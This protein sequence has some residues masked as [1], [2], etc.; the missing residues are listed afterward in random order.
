M[1]RYEDPSL[2]L[3]HSGKL[4]KTKHNNTN[5]FHLAIIETSYP[6]FV[7]HTNHVTTLPDTTL[8]QLCE[9]VYNSALTNL[10][11]TAHANL[12]SLRAIL[13]ATFDS[14]H[15]AFVLDDAPQTQRILAVLD[16]DARACIFAQAIAGILA[17]LRRVA[18]C[19]L[20][21]TTLNQ[22]KV[23]EAKLRAFAE[24]EERREV[25]QSIEM[26]PVWSDCF[27]KAQIGT[28]IVQA[29]CGASAADVQAVAPSKGD[30]QVDVVE[31]D[32][33]FVSEPAFNDGPHL[34]RNLGVPDVFTIM[35]LN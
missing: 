19:S 9:Q 8:F 29:V 35:V 34:K 24:G 32:V 6:L 7:I 28:M 14:A 17:F 25:L 33:D 2:A 22:A 13:S 23:V 30:A 20:S 4:S 16:A 18:S 11:L 1:S 5:S 15:R 3:P 27:E 31:V 12:L 26:S 10:S 21:G